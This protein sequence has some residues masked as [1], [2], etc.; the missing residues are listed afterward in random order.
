MGRLRDRLRS[1]V[2]LPV[3]DNEETTRQAQLATLI[4]WVIVVVPLLY[5]I[6]TLVTSEGS[7]PV[8]EL[9]PVLVASSLSFFLTFAIRRGAVRASSI[10]LVAVLWL[11]FA[12]LSYN[13]GGIR[14]AGYA[15]F[16]IVIVASG[17]LLGATASG[18]SVALSLVVG[19]ILIDAE[20]QG[21]L[22]VD[23]DTPTDIILNY[24]VLFTFAAG[25]VAAAN[26]GYQTLLRS[27]HSGARDLRARNWELQ[28]MRDSLE[29]RVAE[30][31]ADLNRRSRYLEAAARVAYAAGEILDMDQLMGESVDL[32]RE[33]FGLYY[34][35]FFVVDGAREWAVL[36]A[37]TG[38]AGSRMLER[39][40]RIRVGAGMVGWCVAH[41]ES[42]FAQHAAEDE[43]RLVAPE[44]PETRAEAALPLRARGQVQGALTVQSTE[45]DFF[46]EATVTVLQTMADLLAVALSNAQLFE[47]SEQS[48][49]AVRRAYGEMTAEAWTGLL[50]A[51]DD[52]SGW[53]YRYADGVVLPTDG[54]PA[55]AIRQAIDEAA[56]IQ[57]ESEGGSSIALPVSVGGQVVGAINYQRR[58]DEGQ[59]NAE[60]LALLTTLTD[61]LAQA[62]D[63]ARLLQETQRRAAQEQQIN[64]IARRLTNALD[65]ET[66]LRSVV[67]EL[68]QLPG[69][70]EAAVHIDLPEA[71]VG[72]YGAD[73]RGGVNTGSN[74]GVSD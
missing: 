2:T 22:P 10:S 63:S 30:R 15:G 56:P 50:M 49:A 65:M 53:G 62:L 48:M 68:G 43:V 14:D 52:A 70:L 23:T 55:A 13:L 4:A 5:G 42:R 19:L 72:E 3:F 64:D 58:E 36:R 74:G 12:F 67:D 24:F 33:A 59:W 8:T 21:I 39:G 66:M 41:G 60:D 45:P 18:L 27:L 61:Q 69:V 25:L 32:I 1:I 31:T 57:L 26:R 28:Q 71:A 20:A 34:V 73:T 11:G 16:M 9:V 46:D 47:E 54:A 7:V 51:R 38:E 29:G 35:G 40:H 44:L 17:L 37:G 6:Y